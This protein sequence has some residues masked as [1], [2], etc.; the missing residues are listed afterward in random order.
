MVMISNSKVTKIQV[1]FHWPWA[2]PGRSQISG[3]MT[4]CWL[5]TIPLANILS[6]GSEPGDVSLPGMLGDRPII[7]PLEGLNKEVQSVWG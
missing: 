4:G 7:Y 1:L 3:H 5:L 6:H 2:N